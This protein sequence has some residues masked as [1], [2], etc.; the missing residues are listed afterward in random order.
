MISAR[1]TCVSR[2]VFSCEKCNQKL[3]V[4]LWTIGRTLVC[5]KCQKKVTVEM[6]KRKSATSPQTRS[7]AAAIDPLAEFV[8]AVALFAN[9]MTFNSGDDSKAELYNRHD[10]LLFDPNA[11][12]AKMLALLAKFASRLK[13]EISISNQSGRKM[14]YA[15]WDVFEASKQFTR[16]YRAMANVDGRYTAP[17]T[18]PD[19]TWEDTPRNRAKI[20]DIVLMQI[21]SFR[22]ATSAFSKYLSNSSI[23]SVGNVM[24]VLTETTFLKGEV[25]LS[26]PS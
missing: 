9:S 21:N 25:A 24:E 22:P 10:D 6:P 1:K 5:P 15:D 23:F 13:R 20:P 4:R 18:L 11:Y 17:F 19:E 3:S 8:Y 7:Q 26:P 16:I 12:P 14:P 2:F